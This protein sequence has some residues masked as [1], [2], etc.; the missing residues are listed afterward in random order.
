[1][2]PAI[3]KTEEHVAKHVAVLIGQ[4]C[5]TG[6]DEAVEPWRCRRRF[7]EPAKSHRPFGESPFFVVA[8]E[9]QKRVGMAA[10]GRNPPVERIDRGFVALENLKKRP[11]VVQ[12]QPP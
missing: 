1:M 8:P 3:T 12:Q 4:S 10:V 2:P 6:L 5:E 11:F 9:Q 7:V